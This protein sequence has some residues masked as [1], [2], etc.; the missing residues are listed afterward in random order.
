MIDHINTFFTNILD[1][2]ASILYLLLFISSIIEN[3]IPPIPG[4][5]ITAFGA[6]LVGQGKLNFLAVYTLTTIGSTIGFLI[7]FA[8]GWLLGK[9]FFIKRNY[10][11]F[12][13][14]S[15]SAGEHWF[16]RFGLFVVLA[17]RFLPGIRSVI[18]I[19]AGASML[20]PTKVGILALISA[21]I[22][23]LI[24]IHVGYSLGNNWETVRQKTEDIL[25]RYNVIVIIVISAAVLCWFL[26]QM[27][28]KINN[29]S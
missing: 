2:P 7:L 1:A 18:S 14:K 15:I 13:A 27:Y 9:E 20:S 10:H 4:D 5:T 26:Y 23:N 21:S 16:S 12:P 19:V 17:N 3:I 8:L 25:T 22:W 29:N 28:K 24:W 11:F 6:F